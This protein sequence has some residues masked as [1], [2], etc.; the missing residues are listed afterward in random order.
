[1]VVAAAHRFSDLGCYELE[2]LRRA[3]MFRY[4]EGF[5]EKTQL[6]LIEAAY[7]SRYFPGKHA[8]TFDHEEHH[9]E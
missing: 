7:E 1:M 5:C 4:I 3:G 2:D 9:R 8:I 6:G